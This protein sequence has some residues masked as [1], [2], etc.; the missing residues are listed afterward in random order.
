MGV[1]RETQDFIAETETARKYKN[2]TSGKNYC[3]SGEK[4]SPKTFEQKKSTNYVES[5]KTS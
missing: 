1:K 4:V 2:Q 5:R 3:K